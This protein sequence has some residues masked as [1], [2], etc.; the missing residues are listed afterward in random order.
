M[1]T[2][3]QT[4]DSP[5]FYLQHI[6]QA[7][8]TVW[9]PGSFKQR[10]VSSEAFPLQIPELPDK[11]GLWVPN[12]VECWLDHNRLRSLPESFIFI[13]QCAPLLSF[14]PSCLLP[15]FSLSR[16]YHFSFLSLPLYLSISLSLC[17]H[18]PPTPSLLCSTLLDSDRLIAKLSHHLHYSLSLLTLS[19]LTL[20]LPGAGCVT[21][22]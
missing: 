10:I 16:F 17:L 2:A 19:L 21:L 6:P 14:V 8:D 4:V 20:S 11:F 13:D 18:L 3:Q 1:L 5:D 22:G 12:L 15:P 7:A 9:A